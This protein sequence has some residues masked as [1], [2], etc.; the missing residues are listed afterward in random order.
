[1]A[2]IDVLADCFS[3]AIEEGVITKVYVCVGDVVERGAPLFEVESDKANTE[4]VAPVR[5]IVRELLLA[6]GDHVTKDAKVARLEPTDREPTTPTPA[7]PRPP[8]ARGEAA[9]ERC[10]FCSAKLAGARDC[11]RCGAPT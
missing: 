3:G 6:V 2:L 8:A 11:P 9:T 10:R 7:T 5:A 1:M 4:V